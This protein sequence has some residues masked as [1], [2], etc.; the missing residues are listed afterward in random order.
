MDG[1]VYLYWERARQSL[2]TC[3]VHGTS[4]SPIHY[5]AFP[6]KYNF[7]ICMSNKHDIR[8]T[9]GKEIFAPL[10]P[11][12]ELVVTAKI[13]WFEEK[14]MEIPSIYTDTRRKTNNIPNSDAIEAPADFEGKY[15][16]K[17]GMSDVSQALNTT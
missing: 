6:W 14:R 5:R 12:A 10:H 11:L 3:Y 4:I 16:R 13:S 1:Q 8:S 2:P 17:R 15:S 9:D 7:T